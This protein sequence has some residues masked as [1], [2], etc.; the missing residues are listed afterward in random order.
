M[1]TSDHVQPRPKVSNDGILESPPV[2]EAQSNFKNDSP[3]ESSKE[4]VQIEIPSQV[5][6]IYLNSSDK[7][8][9]GKEVCYI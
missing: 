4:A 8:S 5:K 9:L 2:D 3:N 7:V 1:A 6:T